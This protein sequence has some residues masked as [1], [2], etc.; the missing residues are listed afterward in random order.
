MATVVCIVN[1]LGFD[2]DAHCGNY[3][4]KNKLALCKMSIHSNKHYKQLYLSN[5]MECFSC[6]DGCGVHKVLRI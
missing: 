2:I 4:N 1:G 5:M 3:P 6:K